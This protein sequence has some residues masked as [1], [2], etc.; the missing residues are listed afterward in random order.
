MH[1]KPGR[2]QVMSGLARRGQEADA[3][4]THIERPALANRDDKAGQVIT[5][6]GRNIY[7]SA[8]YATK[9]EGPVRQ[10]RE[11]LDRRPPGMVRIASRRHGPLRKRLTIP[12]EARA[13]IPLGSRREISSG[14][15]ERASEMEDER[16][17]P[18]CL[19]AARPAETL[20]EAL[21]VPRRPHFGAG[22]SSGKSAAALRGLGGL[23]DRLR[24]LPLAPT[25]AHLG[26]ELFLG[27]WFATSSCRLGSGWFQDRGS[28]IAQEHR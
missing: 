25:T 12:A 27:L 28:E 8:A 15:D 21:Q 14:K 9:W 16:A 20:T 22:F 2:K 1:T 26:R 4:K 3:N 24:L 19:T 23:P 6:H 5:G 17:G 18:A 11:G 7:C 13:T 10:R